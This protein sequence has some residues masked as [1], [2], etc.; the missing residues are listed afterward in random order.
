MNNLIGLIKT[1]I[2]K[3]HT[4]YG[5]YVDDDA[6]YVMRL[7]AGFK[8]PQIDKK[9]SG[10]LS[11]EHPLSKYLL[12]AFPH[13][14]PFEERIEFRSIFSKKSKKEQPMTKKLFQFLSELPETLTVG[15]KDTSV[16]HYAFAV[17]QR[18]GKT[19]DVDLVVN[20]NQ[21]A[22]FLHSK[23]LIY[24][25]QNFQYSEQN[26][27]LI[28]ATKRS[29]LMKTWK[30][31]DDIGLVPTRFEPG[32]VAAL[33]AAWYK[34]PP[35]S[36]PLPEVRILVGPEMTLITLTK[37]RTPLSWNLI[38][39]VSDNFA[40]SIFPGTQN[41]IIYTR[42]QFTAEG[43][44]RI[45]LQGRNLDKG[46]AAKITEMTGVP[47]E[48][49]EAEP[50]DGHLIAY[51]LA[52]GT[53][54]PEME[55]INLAREVQK[56]VSLLT[57][58][59]YL[60]TFITTGL[61]LLTALYLGVRTERLDKSVRLRSAL[62]SQVSWAAVQ[63]NDDIGAAVKRMNSEMAPL[64]EFYAPKAPWSEILL[65]LSQIMPPAVQMRSIFGQDI[66]WKGKGKGTKGLT[67]MVEC[68]RGP[69]GGRPETE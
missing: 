40:E 65:E 49:H 34:L 37:G 14:K 10:Q 51:G 57:T 12:E 21:K 25:W 43:V 66:V 64:K 5:I 68:V 56:R 54:Y 42:K 61:I 41:L 6:V 15:I 26:F 22:E 39:T 60:E 1:I 8:E 20:E 50:Y 7:V 47:C 35:S 24:E 52:L 36:S 23:K 63:N 67:L 30:E 27:I 3:F 29:G 33:R 32:T 59:P 48:L 18:Q 46:L 9:F 44:A 38:N 11:K 45:V 31:F 69:D 28:S 4:S 58:F 16:F 17:S 53:L 62:N 13:A 2:A 55:N 19:F